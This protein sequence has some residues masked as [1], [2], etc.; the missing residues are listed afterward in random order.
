MKN[1]NAPVERP[2]IRKPIGVFVILAMIALLGWAIGTFSAK[3]GQMHM[4][5]QAVI[6]LIAGVVWIAP[7]KPLLRWMETGK[8][9]E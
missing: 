4:L 9:R 8:W 3:L 2:T 6:Y 5:V 1:E 7:L